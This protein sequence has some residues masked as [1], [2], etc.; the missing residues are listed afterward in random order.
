MQ[1]E[2]LELENVPPKQKLQML[3]NIVG[4]IADLANVKQLS[5]QMVARGGANLGF[6]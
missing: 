6:E 3:Q 5:D 2:K 4:A 1:Y